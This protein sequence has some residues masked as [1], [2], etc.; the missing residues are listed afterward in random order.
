M[1]RI[2]P[3]RRPAT[4]R[5]GEFL[6]AAHLRHRGYRI[7]ARNLRTPVGEIDLIAM[8]G[9][10]LVFVEVKTARVFHPGPEHAPYLNPEPLRSL[11]WRQR[12][13]IRRAAA[14]WLRG[15]VVGSARAGPPHGEPEPRMRGRGAAA[16]RFDAIGVT[17][18]TRGELQRLDHIEGAW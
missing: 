4:G 15:E 9:R 6:A 8:D 14:S 10:V 13:R 12:R 7:V 5:R 1:G 11:R 2:R 18:D 17:L 3:D 16:I